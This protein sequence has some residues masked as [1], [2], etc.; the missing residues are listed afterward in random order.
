MPKKEITIEYI[1]TEIAEIKKGNKE[2]AKAITDL[3]RATARGFEHVEKRFDEVEKR[4][5]DVYSEITWIK[6]ILE[7]HT[8]F[9][10]RLDQERIFTNIH[11][12][13]LEEE[14]NKIKTQLNLN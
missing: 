3:T 14:I 13:R 12:N 5:D 10:L 11:I 1:A 2:M 8:G 9:L 6:D 4:F 7:K